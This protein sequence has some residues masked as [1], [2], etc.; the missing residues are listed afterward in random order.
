MDRLALRHIFVIHLPD[1]PHAL[2]RQN[3]DLT[4]TVTDNQL[5]A[6]RVVMDT[7]DTRSA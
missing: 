1:I 6:R 4:G 7:R 3:I 5:L 2:R